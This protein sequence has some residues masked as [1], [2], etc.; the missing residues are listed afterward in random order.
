MRRVVTGDDIAQVRNP[1]P[2]AVPAWRSPVYRTPL[3]IVAIVHFVRMIVWL[4]R[5]LFR[6]PVLVLAAIAGVL[7][8]RVTGWLG[9]VVLTVSIAA[10]LMARSASVAA[11][12]A[13]CNVEAAAAW[14]LGHGRDLAVLCSG[15]D[16]AFSHENLSVHDHHVTVSVTVPDRHKITPEDLDTARKLAA[17]VEAYI[18]EL[19]TRMAAQDPAADEGEAA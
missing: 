2:F 13:L 1:D 3:A 18:A 4:V 14:A 9:V 16:G 5:F 19:E 10:M 8:W 7:M 12:A 6:H 15:D 11:V 17:A